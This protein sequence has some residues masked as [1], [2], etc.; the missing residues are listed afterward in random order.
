MSYHICTLSIYKEMAYLQIDSPL[1]ETD[2]AFLSAGGWS[3]KVS[4]VTM[5]IGEEPA[6]QEYSAEVYYK[7]FKNETR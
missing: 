5:V 1:T 4:G 7:P 3:R 6:Q 2:K